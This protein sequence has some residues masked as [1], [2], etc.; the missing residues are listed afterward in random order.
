[1]SNIRLQRH[2]A[3]D[4]LVAT[5]AVHHLVIGD[6][7]GSRRQ[8]ATLWRLCCGLLTLRCWVLRPRLEVAR[9][10]GLGLNGSSDLAE[11]TELLV[12][13]TVLS[14]QDLFF[15]FEARCRYSRRR[16]P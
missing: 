15:V 10:T 9:P 12:L 1:M 14:S 3:A 8:Q 5:L 4:D 7:D 13:A 6:V 2:V 11:T 16:F